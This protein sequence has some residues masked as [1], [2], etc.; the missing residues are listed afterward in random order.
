MLSAGSPFGDRSSGGR[1]NRELYRPGSAPPGGPFGAFPWG[2]ALPGSAALRAFVECGAPS[3]NPPG[4]L[5]GPLRAPLRSLAPAP[6]PSASLP[7]R[8][9]RGSSAPFRLSLLLPARRSGVALPPW[10]G[11]PGRSGGPWHASSTRSAPWALPVALPPLRAP[12]RS[13]CAPVGLPPWALLCAAPRGPPPPRALPRARSLARARSPG[14]AWA[15]L[16][17]LRA[18]A[19]APPAAGASPLRF[20]PGALYGPAPAALGPF[21]WALRGLRPRT[22]GAPAGAPRSSEEGPILGPGGAG[23]DALRALPPLRVSLCTSLAVA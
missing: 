5:P 16:G 13:P 3:Q 8:A 7:A 2:G 11:S 15:R 12:C 17:A 18:P 10:G 9:P 20:A 14:Q 19:L 21:L 22:P 1:V 4:P 23:L 6:A